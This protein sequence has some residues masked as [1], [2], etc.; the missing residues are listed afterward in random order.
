M[1]NPNNLKPFTRGYDSRRG[2]KL[3]GSKHLSSYIR[4][5]LEDEK[6]EY[7]LPSGKKEIGPPI[8]SILHALVHKAISGDLKAIDLLAKYGYSKK[9]EV[10]FDEDF[11]VKFTSEQAEQLL[12]LRS[13]RENP[14]NC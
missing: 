13:K 2:S 10:N 5:I 4:D 12:R 8:I 11:R 9:V 14:D 6:F 1:A 7:K 3:K